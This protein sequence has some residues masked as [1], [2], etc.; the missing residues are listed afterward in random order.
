MTRIG[1]AGAQVFAAG[2]R[3]LTVM[4]LRVSERWG[5]EDVDVDVVVVGAGFAG[6]YMLYRLRH[7]GLRARVFEAGRDVGGTWYWNRYPGAR[8]DV[9]S[10]EYSYSF[11]EALQQEW[12]WTERFAGQPEIL[13]YARH[14]ADRF[15]LRSDISFNTRVISAAFDDTARRWTV[16]TSPTG[17]EPVLVTA[18][19]LITAVGCLSSTNVPSFP[20]QDTFC[21]RQF[22][23]GDW[24]HDGVDFT[25]NRVGIIGTGSSGIQ[26]IPEI[27]KV[28]DHLTVFQRTPSYTAPAR[29]HPLAADELAGIKAHYSEL[30]AANQQMSGAHGSRTPRGSSPALDADPD[31]R[32][33]EFTRRWELGGLALLHGYGDLLTN[34]VANDLAADFVR[35][36]IAEI[37][38]DPE[39]AAKLLPTHTIGCKRLCLDTDYFATF[40]RP[41]VSLVDM[42]V[43]PLETITADGIVAAGVEHPL[44]AIVYATGFDAMTGSL[45]KLDLHGP[46]TSLAAEWAAGPVNYLGLGVVGLPNLL[47]I[48]GPGSPSVLTNMLASIEYQVDWISHLLRGMRASGATRVEATPDAQDGWVDHVNAV[49]AGTLFP[50]C[51]SWYL[52]ANVPG[53]P[54]VFMPLPGH[55]AYVARCNEVAAAGYPGFRIS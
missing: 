31:E 45:L 27:A 38:D 53:K 28:A 47:I 26:C 10:V 16:A 33:A 18:R 54:R 17:G 13:D 25:G 24:P 20:G 6:M 30:R 15:E 19:L 34:P 50:T 3:S 40:N 7:L 5:G 9:E 12:N 44:D 42:R 22:H 46:A 39:T 35:R 14:V 37:V 41:N 36:R 32:E 11:D 8:C 23:T 2:S 52:G 43:E 4:V 1:F 49:A 48:T 55:P 21:G 51:N 29:N